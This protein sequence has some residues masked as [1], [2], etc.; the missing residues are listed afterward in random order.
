MISVLS[1]KVVIF[2]IEMKM[3]KDED[4]ELYEYGMF[5]ML[6]NFIFFVL[7]GLLGWMQGNIW[8]SLL[9]Y[10]LFSALR[11]Y[12]GGY[13]AKSEAECTC[14][15]TI[16]LFIASYAISL[17]YKA[18]NNFFLICL[19]VLCSY[20]VCRL[21]PL[22]SGNKPIDNKEKIAYRKKTKG[23][24]YTF[25]FFSFCSVALKIQGIFYAVIVSLALECV[26]I[27]LGV[28]FPQE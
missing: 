27:I 16:A 18:N 19:L 20:V 22:D 5:I 8:E 9:F 13:H 4:R 10:V 3:V 1:K 14:Y 23:L 2:L 26:L 12:A 17:L 11:C 21:S 25:V 7:S 6:S 24:V 15:T 28:L